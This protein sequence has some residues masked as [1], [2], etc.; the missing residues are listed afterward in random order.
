MDR[1]RCLFT[2]I[3]EEGKIDVPISFNITP[4]H[5]ADDE[6][7]EAYESAVVHFRMHRQPPSKDV[8]RA[9]HPN[10]TFDPAPDALTWYLEE[11][12]K[13]VNRRCA[14]DVNRRIA[15]AI[16]DRS[17]LLDI[18]VVMVE[19]ARMLSQLMPSSKVSRFSDMESR[20]EQYERKAAIGE[21]PGL[22]SRFK[23]VNDLT[24]GAQPYENWVILAPSG[25]GKSTISQSFIFDWWT[26]EKTSLLVSMEMGADQLMRNWDAMSARLSRAA[27]K[28][29]RLGEGDIDRWRKIAKK[30]EV[31]KA[32]SDIIVLDDVAGCTPDKIWAETFKHQ[33]DVVVV[34][35]I[36]LLESPRGLSGWQAI[37]HNAKQLKMNARISGIPH[38]VIAQTNRSGFSD[39]ARADNVQGSIGITQNADVMIGLY[40]E[41]E[42]WEDEHRLGMR[43]PKN[44]DGRGHPG[45]EF[46]ADFDTMDIYEPGHPTDMFANSFLGTRQPSAAPAGNMWMDA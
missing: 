33:P 12:R 44:R 27:I 30:A 5:F 22:M 29:L 43:V 45:F 4:E 42:S 38:V 16:Q 21:N 6:V 19:G 11:F 34:D 13:D 40:R 18:D 46:H 32:T 7:S 41:G 2:K 28:A 9:K 37:S 20:I 3:I 39:G 17:R 31:A 35:Y 8:I 10:F 14:I 26:Q 25:M 1:E 24:Y 15:L 23:T 36:D